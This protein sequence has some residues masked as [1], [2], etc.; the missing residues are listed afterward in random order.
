MDVPGVPPAWDGE[1][2]CGYWVFNL[3]TIFSAF[4]ALAIHSLAPVNIFKNV[5]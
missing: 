5:L 1:G 4:S 2:G 3:T